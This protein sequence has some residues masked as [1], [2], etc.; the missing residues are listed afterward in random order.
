MTQLGIDVCMLACVLNACHPGMC[1]HM[2]HMHAPGACTSACKQM[3]PTYHQR[4]LNYISQYLEYPGNLWNYWFLTVT[5]HT[6][7]PPVDNWKLFVKIM[8][9]LFFG[10]GVPNLQKAG[11]NKIATP[12]NSTTPH[13]ATDIYIYLTP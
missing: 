7:H 2:M 4:G 11:I 6:N 3:V 9:Y 8:G 10:M 13:P 5:C 1:E 12:P